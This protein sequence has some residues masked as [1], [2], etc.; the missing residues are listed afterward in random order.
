MS[1]TKTKKIEKL[2]EKV[3]LSRIGPEEKKPIIDVCEECKGSKF[4]NKTECDD[5]GTIY[6]TKE[7]ELPE[8]NRSV[9]I[10]IQILEYL[11]SIEDQ[12]LR[13][14]IISHIEDKNDNIP[15]GSTVNRILNQ[16]K[17]L[18]FLELKGRKWSYTNKEI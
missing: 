4:Y 15:S 6:I 10:A 1:R 11:S 13:G 9:K 18:G 14:D 2:C 17:E 5:Q 7:L 8:Y 12:K 3:R 16:L